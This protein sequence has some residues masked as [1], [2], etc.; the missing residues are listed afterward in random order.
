MGHASRRLLAAAA[1]A[2]A[3]AAAAAA[4]APD[5][6]TW[7]RGVNYVPTYA[8]NDIGTLVDYDP[9]VVERE[10]GYAG[11]AGFN[12]VRLFLH[13]LP[14]LHN[15]SAFF[16]AT[17]HFLAAAH[18]RG[19][20]VL[21]VVL[22]SCF[23]DVNPDV[24]WIVNGTYR[25]F[26]WIPNPGPRMVGDPASW[27]ALDW[28]VTS[29][30]GRY[31]GDPRLLGWDVMNEPDFA[32]PGMDAF[33]AHYV[34]LVSRLDPDPSHVV[35][36]GLAS[37][38]DQ[39]RVAGLVRTLSFHDYDGGGDGTALGRTIAAQQAAAAAASKAVFLSESMGRP[40]QGLGAVLPAV[41]GCLG[42]SAPIG[43]ML[44]ELM[45]GRDQFNANWA[46]PYQGL[47]FPQT[48]P[49]AAWPPGGTWWSA[50]EAALWANYT[51]AWAPPPGGAGVGC[52]PPPAPGAATWLPDTAPA[53]AYTPAGAWTAWAGAGPPNG[54]LHY[55]NATGA[56]AT[57]ALPPGTAAA[58]V[59][60]K[61][62]PDCGRFTVA[63]DGRAGAA[64]TVDAYDPGVDWGA[65]VTA[66]AGLDPA[67]AHTL[68]VTAA[69]AANPAAAGAYT[70]LV[71][72]LAWGAAPT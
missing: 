40:G 64:V 15:Q 65:V 22:D 24:S 41:G 26:T 10:L 49:A 23:G 55:A 51:R 45:L 16:A 60:Y 50:H 72:V 9:A 59:V 4:T 68:V 39:P 11:A 34:G 54:T 62:G 21:L 27:V 46:Q 30:V 12:G 18:A 58:A 44:W 29:L 43:F 6:L 56:A 1:T 33:L 37:A 47:V 52:R 19:L 61:V 14:W 2:L 57:V 28:Y 67:V 53:V 66:A 69:G 70:Q 17:D 20:A 48:A 8:S 35:T 42:V 63:V 5:D 38:G 7:L 71:G 25:N 36:V 3:A 31:A 13:W 32:N